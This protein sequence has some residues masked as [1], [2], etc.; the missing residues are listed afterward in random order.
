MAFPAVL[1]NH[2]LE[3]GPCSCLIP[4]RQGI[5][6]HDFLFRITVNCKVVFNHC[7]FIALAT[8]TWLQQINVSWLQQI[9]MS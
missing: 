7:D 9:N 3:P 4:C 1:L 8:K 5:N 2:L 6:Q